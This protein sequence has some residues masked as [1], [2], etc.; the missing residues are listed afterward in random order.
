[1][2]LLVKRAF[3]LS[4][5]VI[6]A[7]L[8][9]PLLAIIALAIRIRM[10]SPVLFRQPRPGLHGRIFFFLKFRTMSDEKDNAGELLPDTVRLTS[11]GRMLRHTSLDELPQFWNVLKGDMSLVGPRPLL[12]EYLDLYSEAQQRRHWMRPGITGLAQI[13]GRNSL[14]WETKFQYDLEYVDRWKLSLDFQILFKTVG[15]LI[16]GRGVDQSATV[17][18]PRFRGTSRLKPQI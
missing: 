14:D 8:L 2:Q 16:T 17:T 11:L 9:L 7:P 13:S 15:I 5:V 6:A 10:G 18:M 4:A 1:M 12:V 3:D